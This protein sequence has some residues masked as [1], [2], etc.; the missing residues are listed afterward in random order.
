MKTVI[1]GGRKNCDFLIGS[2]LHRNHKLIVINDDE[3]YCEYL[4]T[5][6]QIPVISGDPSDMHILDKAHIK[7]FDS[8]ISLKTDDADNLAICQGAKLI[9][10]IKKTVCIVSNPK[11]IE[12]FKKLGVDTVINT[13]YM[14]A[15]LIEHE[16]N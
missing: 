3:K 13:E 1:A 2:L 11:N 14:V 12:V 16:L 4:A 5:K 10:A 8:L 6:Y 7:G 15:D 9:Y